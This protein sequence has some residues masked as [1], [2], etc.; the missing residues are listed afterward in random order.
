MPNVLQLSVLSK[1]DLPIVDACKWR[2]WIMCCAF[3]KMAARFRVCQRE[4]VAG[5]GDN[6]QILAY[7]EEAN[8]ASTTAQR[9][10]CITR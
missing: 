8:G 6:A 4:A 10:I 1:T 2:G 7:F 3:N 5:F 9:I